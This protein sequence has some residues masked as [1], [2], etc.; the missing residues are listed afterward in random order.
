MPASE[1]TKVDINQLDIEARPI[2][3]SADIISYDET[4]HT[5]ELTQEAFTRV[6]QIFPMPVKVDGIPFVVCVGEERIYT[7][8][9]W[10]PLSSLSYDGVVIM[11]PFGTT[12]TVIQIS[13]GYPSQD[14]F[15]GK[16]P[17]TDPRIMKTFGQE[18]KLK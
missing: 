8:A 3:S 16:D 7:G 1:L 4:N 2:I 9:F 10:T 14:F 15:T 13:L 18:K 17:R 12:G 6:Q 11:Q 5:I